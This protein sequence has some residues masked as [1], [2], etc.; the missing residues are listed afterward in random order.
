MTR[1]LWCDPADADQDSHGFESEDGRIWRQTGEIADSELGA[2]IGIDRS[3]GC[4]VCGS[5]LMEN[6]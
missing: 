3:A 4:P 2:P 5:P 1:Y 6:E